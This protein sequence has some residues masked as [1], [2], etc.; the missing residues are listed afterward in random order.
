MR[1]SRLLFFAFAAASLAACGRS[2]PEEEEYDFAL[3]ASGSTLADAGTKLDANNDSAGD[4][5]A[6]QSLDA[7]PDA[8]FDAPPD[9][10]LDQSVDVV[11]D[12]PPD[13]AADAPPDVADDVKNDGPTDAKKDG[14]TDAKK[15]QI[16]FFDVIPFPDSGPIATCAECA[17][18]HCS[19]QINNCFNNAAC[20][21][22][23]VC[24][25]TQC[26]SGGQPSFGCLMGCFNGNFSAMFQAIGAFQCVINQCGQDC[27]GVVGGG[28]GSSGGG[29]VDAAPT[30]VPPGGT[31]GG[32]PAGGAGWPVE[33]PSEFVWPEGVVPPAG[34]I[35]IPPPQAFDAYPGV[36]PACGA[37]MRPACESKP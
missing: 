37:W 24:A 5:A 2:D 14:P 23:V 19:N 31:P 17:Q 36:I 6:D 15:D 7:K 34:P 16:D 1:R 12:V 28:G 26:F 33:V 10:A 32:L 22:G 18:Q 35:V 8:T 3:D 30:P 25:F 27:A 29:T 11:A 21:S 9:I 4:V 13:V 20:T